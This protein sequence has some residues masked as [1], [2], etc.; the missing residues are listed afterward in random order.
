MIVFLIGLGVQGVGR[1][2]AQLTPNDKQMEL[3]SHSW[4]IAPGQTARIS[5]VNFAAGSG[6][7]LNGSARSNDPV[8]ARIQL[9]DTEGEVSAQS[10]EILVAPGQVRFWDAPH[11]SLL[12]LGEPRNGRIQVRARILV[13]TSPSEGRR[14]RTPLG[15]TVELVDPS[16]GETT[17]YISAIDN[18]ANFQRFLAP[19]VP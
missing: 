17:A 18:F 3:L 9:L 11:E 15:A 16:T 12:T 10:D 7:S 1:A 4:G 5:L 6:R 2:N 14:N 13:T 19:P 8:I